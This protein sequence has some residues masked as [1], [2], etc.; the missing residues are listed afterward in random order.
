MS[1]LSPLSGVK[2]KLDFGDV[3]AV[4]DPYRKSCRS[5]KARRCVAIS[6]SRNLMANLFDPQP[7]T[8]R[9]AL[10]G[11]SRPSVLRVFRFVT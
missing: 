8:V 9:S 5:T 11:S 2:Q 7:P 3:R 6:Y 4:D 1:D 10:G